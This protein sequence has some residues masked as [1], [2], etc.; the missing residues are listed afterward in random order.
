[1][2]QSMMEI[3]GSEGGEEHLRESEKEAPAQKVGS[4]HP[5]RAAGGSVMP[6]MQTR[7]RP[8]KI[9]KK[10][11]N[12]MSSREKI[13]P[14]F[15]LDEFEC[16]CSCGAND[17]SMDLVRRIQEV[18]DTLGEPMR[19]TSGVR[20]SSHNASP[21]VGGSPNSSHIEGNSTAVD[22][23]CHNSVYRQ[24]LLKS[25]MPVFDRVGIA[26][27]FIHCDVDPNKT[28]GVIWLY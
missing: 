25:I 16:K 1:M 27:T 10:I 24:K 3:M 22:I 17:I 4:L 23:A 2:K 15:Y 12:K 13:S 14:N 19:I 26:K 7:A 5:P 6:S 18:R 28:A 9:L 8:Q 11:K 21:S 20:C